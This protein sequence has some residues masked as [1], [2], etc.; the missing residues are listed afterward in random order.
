MAWTLISYDVISNYR[1]TYNIRRTLAVNEIVDHSDVGAAPTTSLFS[2]W[3][4]WIAK[5]HLQDEAT[6]I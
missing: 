3:L 6:I 1:Q 5:R 4:Q 2:T